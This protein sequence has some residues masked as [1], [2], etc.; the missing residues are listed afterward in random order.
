MYAFFML[1][2]GL[3]PGEALALQRK[4]VDLKKRTVKVNKTYLEKEKKIQNSTKTLSSKRIVPIPSDTV[5]LLKQ[6][7]LKQPKK[8]PEDPLF[9]T[10]TGRRPTQSYLRKRFRFAGDAIKCNWV[11]LHTMRHTY[12]SRLF[13]K[14]I[15]IKV[16]SKLLGHK[17]VSTTYDIYVHLIDDVVKKSVKVLNTGKLAKLPE[18]SRKKKDNVRKLKKASTH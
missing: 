13:Q 8:D 5:K 15:D 7:M 12:A 16:I 3:R 6:Y 4:D 14:K 17:K 11:N 10:E 1:N 9:Q 18:K 2:T